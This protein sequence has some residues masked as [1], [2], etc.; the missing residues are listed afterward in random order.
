MARVLIIGCGCRGRELAGELLEAGHTVRGTTRQPGQLQAIEAAGA[1]AVIADPDRVATLIPAFAGVAVAC[2]LLGS[3]TGAPDAL[4]ALHTTRLEMLLTRA[5]DTTIRGVVYE[6]TGTIDP[7]VLEA[8]ARIVRT[9][10]DESRIPHR[11]LLAPG[12][13]T[14]AIEELLSPGG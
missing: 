8:G 13:A 2:L 4:R 14:R 3:A 12:E 9:K 11:I 6:A 10:C 5:I 7:D 1:E